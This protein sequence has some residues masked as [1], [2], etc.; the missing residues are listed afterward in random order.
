MKTC[1][2][3]LQ[4]VD[5]NWRQLTYDLVFSSIPATLSLNKTCGGYLLVDYQKS[6]LL[7]GDPT[8]TLKCHWK[9]LKT[10]PKHFL[11]ISNKR[12]L[13]GGIRYLAI[14]VDI[15]TAKLFSHFFSIRILRATST[16]ALFSAWHFKLQ[17][18]L[19]TRFARITWNLIILSIRVRSYVSNM[20]TYTPYKF[21]GLELGSVSRLSATSLHTIC[22]KFKYN[23]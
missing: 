21:S 22:S 2:L 6:I 23:E 20:Y 7:C 13:Y 10:C 1:V 5:R 17:N 9:S 8:L 16:T 12:H 4:G 3:L 18:H 15:L 11:Y 14:P 19:A